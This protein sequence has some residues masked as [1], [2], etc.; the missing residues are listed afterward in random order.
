[1]LLK[2]KIMNIIRFQ[3]KRAIRYGILDGDSIFSL[4]G[5]ILDKFSAGEKLC[6]LA[7]V[8]LMAPVKPNIVVGLGG[9]YRSLLAVDTSVH[10]KPQAFLKPPSAVIGPLDNIIYPDIAKNV[11]MEGELAV[12]MKHE[13]MHVPEEKALDYVL[14]YTCAN[15]VTGSITGDSNFTRAKAFYTFCP[16]GP[17]IATDLDPDDLKITSR[18]N[19]ALVQNADS[20][21][22]M[23]YNVAQI[24]SYITGFMALQPLDVILTGTSRP[25][26]FIKSGDV[27]EIEIE[28]IGLLRNAV[29][30]RNS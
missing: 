26:A 13:A 8:K 30:N 12:I 6:N 9:N 19:G 17:S 1:M 11:H 16:L 10:S 27:V 3:W 29:I 24:I 25:P 28:Q 15:D 22:D 14:G 18:L 4:E 5:N 2:E 20:T 7:D 21:S 23:V